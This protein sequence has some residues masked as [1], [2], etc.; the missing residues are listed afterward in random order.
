MRGGRPNRPIPFFIP[1]WRRVLA[2]RCTTSVTTPFCNCRQFGTMGIGLVGALTFLLASSLLCGCAAVQPP[3]DIQPVVANSVSLIPLDWY[4]F[5]SEEMPPHPSALDGGGWYLDLPSVAAGHVNYAQTP[6]RST[7]PPHG[8]TVTFR[9]ESSAPQYVVLDSSDV[10]PA[11]V[12]I[13]FEQQGDDLVNSDGRWW[14]PSSCYNLGSK[15]NETITISVPLASEYWSNVYGQ[16]N[17]VAFSGALK[18]IG[19]IGLTFGGQ[20]FW[21]HGVA[22]ASGS[23]KLVLTGFQVH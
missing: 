4:I 9:L 5:Y 14:A 13:F 22:L 23:A 17:E 19:W 1:H 18:N 15:D 20:Y 16:S 2:I 7:E 3:P 11:T 10:L 6:F 21:G 12:H 8:V